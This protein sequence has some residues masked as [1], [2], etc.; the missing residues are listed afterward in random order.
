M[1]NPLF[2]W[3]LKAGLILSFLF[4]AYYL[5]FRK[6]TQFQLKRVLQVVI[7]LAAIS[8]PL[9]KISIEKNT[10]PTVYA[11][12]Q[13]DNSLTKENPVL[14]PS[15][16][17]LS[18]S[19][20][21]IQ[22]SNF[23]KAAIIWWI[24]LV[25]VSLSVLIILIEL[26]KLSYL[27]FKGNRESNLGQNVIS[28]P[29]IKYPFSFM[30][31]IFIPTHSEYS[32]DDWRIIQAHENLHLQQQH[33]LDIL[34]ASFTQCLL[35]YHPAVYLIQR[36][37]KANHESLADSA[38]L[39]STP[40][41]QYSKTLLA[42]SLRTNTLTLSHSFSVIS[43]LSKRLK[44]MKI[45]KTPNKKTYLSMFALLF[46]FTALGVQTV[47]YGQNTSIDSASVADSE[48]ENFSYNDIYSFREGQTFSSVE[49]WEKTGNRPNGW[50]SLRSNSSHPL[51]IILSNKYKS[52]LANLEEVVL[53][54]N[55][56]NDSKQILRVE[57]SENKETYFSKL[58]VNYD[59]SQRRTEFIAELTVEERL[60]FYELSKAWVEDNIRHVY[61]DYQLALEMDVI[62]LKY[63]IIS[64][65][66]TTSS[67]RK[68]NRDDVF[69]SN[70]VDI[71]AEPVGG[72]DRFLRNVALNIE[73]DP[74]INS[75]DYPE[76]IE[77]EFLIYNSGNI[78]M[79][80][81]I[82]DLPDETIKQ[83]QLYGL[84]KQINDNLIK[85]S[86]LYGW[87]PALKNQEPV[88][89][90]VRIQFPKSLL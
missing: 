18:I 33:T 21:E 60:A 63:I 32:E 39:A 83:K 29:S 46:L 3:S 76:K 45:K 24:Y 77:F 57:L 75:S 73:K 5:L 31:W 59:F 71:K 64:S 30:K 34:F 48:L 86:R 22:V 62:P 13:L 47:A 58:K 53:N 16:K 15:E 80:N 68:F 36:S 55:S 74:T 8:F 9:I 43:S 56:T 82:T 41:N 12:Q 88:N 44:L 50:L 17:L 54:E 69:S 27:V 6:N 81:L 1:W 85:I 38:V 14:N 52:L 42:L 37:M 11:F 61:P 70:E 79:V 10:I 7:L 28:H 25:G 87:N 49:I 78:S 4:A 26:T 89:S 51:P 19:Q 72:L 20:E 40:Y 90:K 2:I 35:W 84:M 23:S 67:K 66:K 65:L